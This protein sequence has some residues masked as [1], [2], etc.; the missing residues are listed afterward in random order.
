MSALAKPSTSIAFASAVAAAVCAFSLAAEPAQADG[1]ALLQ[2]TP[3]GYFTPS[4]GRPMD[5]AAWHIDAAGAQRVIER[6]RA[7]KQPPVI[8][9]EH[10][11]LHK[12]K[13]G[14]PAPAA[15]W[16]RDLRWIEGRGLFAAA[17][18]TS[19][20]RH[21][22]D[23]KQYLYFSPVFA[24]DGDTGEVIAILM[25]AFTN[26]PAI[27]GM[28]A[29]SLTAA[30]SARFV[31]PTTQE[32]PVNPLLKAVLA[33]LGLPETTTEANA[34]TALSA[35]GP[36]TDV[37][38]ARAQ[39]AAA[40]KE[41]QLGADATGDAVVA[42]CTSLRTAGAANPDLSK[43]VPIAVV[44]EM[45]TSLAALTSQVN[46]GKLDQVIE[47][48]LAEG[49]L[50]PAQEA[51]ARDLGKSNIAALT[52]YLATATPIQALSRQQSAGKHLDNKNPGQGAHGLTEDEL[53]V[54]AAT[55]VTPEQ[56]AKAKA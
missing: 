39:A 53:K 19:R 1:L 34:V 26:N 24:Y 54:A 48:A 15:G 55:G 32:H 37:G 42:A 47:G 36:L 50:L 52:G 23:D 51:W 10:Q 45:R 17:E 22:I 18:L 12:E 11:T 16:I 44:D 49:K 9:Y 3:A 25:G 35:L 43:Y 8:D 28:D 31:S 29:L 4:D 38:A 6:F 46:Q 13:N 7:S 56:F 21:E 30:A 14:Q 33:A 20:A 5:V 40:R 2:V 41:L 27:H